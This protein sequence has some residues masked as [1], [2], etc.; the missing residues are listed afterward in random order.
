MFSKRQF[1]HDVSLSTAAA[2]AKPKPFATY[3]KSAMGKYVIAKAIAVL[4]R[5]L[6]ATRFTLSPSDSMDD[7]YRRRPPR[8]HRRA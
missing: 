7:E 8:A 1:A 2:S 3:A 6:P 5:S 4:K